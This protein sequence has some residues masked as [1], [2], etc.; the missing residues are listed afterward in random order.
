MELVFQTSSV[1]DSFAV[2][3]QSRA[4]VP[5]GHADKVAQLIGL[6]DKEMA[7]ILNLSERTLHRLRP[8]ARLD[9]NASERLIL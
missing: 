2:I 9:N 7:R 8:E 6:T 5:R 1:P 3:Q 4:G